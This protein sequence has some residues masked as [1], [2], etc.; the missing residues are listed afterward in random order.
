VPEPATSAARRS[1]VSLSWRGVLGVAVVVFTVA[2][3][4]TTQSADGDRS[5]RE[6]ASATSARKTITIDP[7]I[8]E[9]LAPAP[10]SARPRLTARQAWAHYMRQLGYPRHTALPSFIRVRLGLF[11]LPIGPGGTGPYTAHNELAYGYSSP[12]ACTTRNPRVLFPRN[13]RCVY[14][15]FLD[16]NTGNQ[17]ES[18]YQAV[19]HWQVLTDFNEMLPGLRF[20]LTFN[21]RPVPYPDNGTIPRYYIRP[22]EH[23]LMT[24][25]V[26]VP[27]HLLIT[28]LWL[29]VAKSSGSN[30]PNGRHA[31]VHPI[32]VISRPL[33]AGV[34]AFSLSWRVP[35][36][37]TFSSFFLVLAWASRQPP[38]GIAGAIAELA[39]N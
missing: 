11:T 17:I 31:G 9:V 26:T 20:A 7:Q 1:N 10:A 25:A 2:G 39:L 3:C 34:H 22:G 16:A 37:R 33:S 21:G 24:V 19:G 14:W 13:A 30:T 29:G 36:H 23:L 4:A 8:G 35:E 32:V 12:S 28:G 38:A 15:D 27:K 5:G 6:G 18:T